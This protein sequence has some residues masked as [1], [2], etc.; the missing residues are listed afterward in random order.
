MAGWRYAFFHFADHYPLPDTSDSLLVAAATKEDAY[1]HEGQI[2]LVYLRRH[3][4]LP[5]LNYKFNWALSKEL[6][7]HILDKDI[8]C[9]PS[10]PSSDP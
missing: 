9:R 5:P 1:R 7:W 8:S 6:G 3:A 2:L 4:E 10:G